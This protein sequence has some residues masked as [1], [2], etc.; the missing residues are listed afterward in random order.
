MKDPGRTWRTSPRSIARVRVFV[1]VCDQVAAR[2]GMWS[3]AGVYLC[4]YSETRAHIN[5]CFLKYGLEHLHHLRVSVWPLPAAPPVP[6]SVYGRTVA[7]PSVLAGGQPY[8]ATHHHQAGHSPF[9]ARH[10]P[11]FQSQFVHE[12]MHARRPRATSRPKPLMTRQAPD[13]DIL[14][15]T[16]EGNSGHPV[17]SVKHQQWRE[18]SKCKATANFYNEFWIQR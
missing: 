16:R 3:K 6:T 4:E 15:L 5:D 13:G 12:H 10:N 2:A 7:P 17:G 18:M 1:C 9:A 11:T 8:A 14:A